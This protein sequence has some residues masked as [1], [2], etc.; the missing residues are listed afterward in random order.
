MEVELDEQPSTFITF[1]VHNLAL[2][3]QLNLP[4][5]FVVTGDDVGPSIGSE[6]LHLAA[7]LVSTMNSLFT[8]ST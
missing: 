3:E 1:N 4:F 5:F 7:A 8:V 2:F 6:Y